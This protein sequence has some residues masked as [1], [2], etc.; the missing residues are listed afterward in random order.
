MAQ[1][2]ALVSELLGILKPII[3]PSE[4]ERLDKEFQKLREENDA[5]KK[6]IKEALASD[7]LAALNVLLAELLE[8]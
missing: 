6:R 7:D 4:Y 1:I 3:S 5:K 8:L 2:I